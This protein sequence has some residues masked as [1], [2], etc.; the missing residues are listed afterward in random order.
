[1]PTLIEVINEINSREDDKTVMQ[2][3][4]ECMENIRECGRGK[5]KHSVVSFSTTNI[6]PTEV[7]RQGGKVGIVLWMDREQWKEAIEKLNTP[8]DNLKK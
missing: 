8:I 4:S 1:M 3:L 5:N 6:S 2:N 7:V